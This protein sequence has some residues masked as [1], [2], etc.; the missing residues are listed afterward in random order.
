MKCSVP[1][2]ALSSIGETL[3]I[4]HLDLPNMYIAMTF[5]GTLGGELGTVTR[6]LDAGVLS[7]VTL[8][9]TVFL[10]C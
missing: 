1:V 10:C 8:T 9:S 3:P 2:A 7:S 6:E 5:A 4:L